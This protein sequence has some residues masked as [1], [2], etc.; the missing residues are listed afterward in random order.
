MIKKEKLVTFYKSSIYLLNKNIASKDRIDDFDFN[1]CINQN[2]D[3]PNSFSDL[4]YKIIKI[5]AN[6]YQLKK[7]NN[8]DPHEKN[9]ID[10]NNLKEA[11][12]PKKAEQ[13]ELDTH[14][15][16]LYYDKVFYSSNFN[17]AERIIKE[18]LKTY[19]VKK[20]G[21]NIDK[22]EIEIAKI[23]GDRDSFYAKIKEVISVELEYV[24]RG[25]FVDE[26]FNKFFGN[27]KI[28]KQTTK[29][30]L[31]D[32]VGVNSI[33]YLFDKIIEEKSVYSKVIIEGSDNNKKS[34]FY[35]TT[36]F[37]EQFSF[38]VKIGIDNHLDNNG[39]INGLKENINGL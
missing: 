6:I 14:I 1:E 7:A 16:F 9:V 21:T 29:V 24:D 8:S 39:I 19:Y 30:Y 36:M 23:L 38:N 20:T 15:Y 26:K 11:I 5:D 34:I 3:I 35:D 22:I 28:K 2:I 32:I 31:N 4:T 13:K 25:M 12:N 10:I 17:Q 27:N 18:V 37:N 33:K